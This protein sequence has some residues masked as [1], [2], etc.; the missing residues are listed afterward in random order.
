[1]NGRQGAGAAS[2]VD[3]CKLHE[4]RDILRLFGIFMPN[5]SKTLILK[6][7]LW[8][9]VGIFIIAVIFVAIGFLMLWNGE[10]LWGTITAG[11]FSLC[12]VYPMFRSRIA[13]VADGEGITPTSALKKGSTLK[14]PWNKIQNIAVATQ[15][16]KTGRQIIP[17]KHKFVA[18]YLN[19]PNFADAQP[20]LQQLS[21][22]I[23]S[24]A[25]GLGLDDGGKAQIYIPRVMLPC[26]AEEAVQKLKD[27]QSRTTAMSSGDK[28]TLDNSGMIR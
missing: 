4:E 16:I 28:A 7:P 8:K 6:Q 27:L 19:D 15:T 26:S 14:I 25:G 5:N 1:M 22:E 3:T 9:K 11:F 20:L 18:I 24:S 2:L 17:Q 21:T 12:A 10:Y 23:T 13:L